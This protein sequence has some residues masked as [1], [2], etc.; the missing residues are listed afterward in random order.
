MAN[1]KAIISEVQK[2]NYVSGTNKKTVYPVTLDKAVKV[3]KEDGKTYT[4]LVNAL[5]SKFGDAIVLGF[6]QDLSAEEKVQEY[7]MFTFRYGKNMDG[8][9]LGDSINYKETL[10]TALTC[11]NEDFISLCLANDD[12]EGAE[13]NET[14]QPQTVA[15]LRDRVQSSAYLNKL[16]LRMIHL[17]GTDIPTIYLKDEEG[18]TYKSGDTI[19]FASYPAKLW[20]C[21]DNMSPDYIQYCKDTFLDSGNKV[22]HYLKIYSED[23]TSDSDS[24]EEENTKV[25][26]HFNDSA[27]NA[28]NTPYENPFLV[29]RYPEDTTGYTSTLNRFVDIL[30]SDG[31]MLYVMPSDYPYNGTPEEVTAYCTQVKQ[32][33]FRINDIFKDAREQK[34]SINPI[35]FPSS[36]FNIIF[37]PKQEDEPILPFAMQLQERPVIIRS[38]NNWT[39]TL[40]VKGVNATSSVSLSM[41]IPSGDNDIRFA[42]KRADSLSSEYTAT[43]ELTPEEV[44]TGIRISVRPVGWQD[45]EMYVPFGKDTPTQI[46]RT[47]LMQYEET[48]YSVDLHCIIAKEDIP[49]VDSPIVEEYVED[50]FST[51]DYYCLLRVPDEWEGVKITGID[52][53]QVSPA[54]FNMYYLVPRESLYAEMPGG[55]TISNILDNIENRLEEPT[56]AQLGTLI[57]T[58][59]C[60][61]VCVKINVFSGDVNNPLPDVGGSITIAN[62]N[63]MSEVIILKYGTA[64]NQS[65][66][67]D[68]YPQSSFEYNTHVFTIPTGD[69]MNA[70][71]ITGRM[72]DYSTI[73]NVLT[74]TELKEV[75]QLPSGIFSGLEDLKDASFVQHMDILQELPKY[76]FYNCPNL[77][78]V[79]LPPN[80]TTIDDYAFAGCTSLESLVIP[81]S[82]THIGRGICEGCTALT[83]VVF[84]AGLT[85]V[86]SIYGFTDSPLTDIWVRSEILPFI[87]PPYGLG[88]LTPTFSDDITGENSGSV[89]LHFL[90]EIKIPIQDEELHVIGY[91]TVTLTDGQTVENSPIA[92]TP[93]GLFPNATIRLIEVE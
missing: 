23:T 83:E 11:P 51:Y 65:Q 19:N 80:I 17:H 47:I 62:A 44:N 7:Y 61:Y 69:R 10:I 6:W 91:D 5:N 53:R 25:A 49:I 30:L 32:G 29:P 86:T 37:T 35:G 57:N 90:A 88:I 8:N 50:S 2:E 93:W 81:D 27:P 82:V 78:T 84:G 74:N 70:G 72:T 14:L 60:K 9:I 15:S 22:Y 46:D 85:D 42:F 48:T 52:A 26:M 75:K 33:I 77:D 28:V 73:E 31:F 21:A 76:A 16:Y 56:K 41:Y 4:T 87:E 67:V 34:E 68:G 24:T 55:I 12:E 1:K 38:S 3:K 39:G 89:T 40:K 71:N 36:Y 92:N 64:A 58:S 54:T 79:I 59:S 45:N 13:I 20:L 18:N 43:L 66:P 63:N